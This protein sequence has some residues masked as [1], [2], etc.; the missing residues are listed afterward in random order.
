MNQKRKQKRKNHGHTLRRP[1]IIIKFT[2]IIPTSKIHK[3]SFFI[4]RNPTKMVPRLAGPRVT[5]IVP[6]RRS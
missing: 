5:G 1:T 3:V 6:G 4:K 2:I